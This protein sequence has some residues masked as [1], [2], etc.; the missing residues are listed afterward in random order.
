[1]KDLTTDQKRI[2]RAVL[3]VFNDAEHKLKTLQYGLTDDYPVMQLTVEYM[4]TQ[5]RINRSFLMCE[6]KN[7]KD[8]AS[9][10]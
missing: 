9:K 2:L 3:D 4:V 10:K 5:V 7:I 6:A 1:M 8:N